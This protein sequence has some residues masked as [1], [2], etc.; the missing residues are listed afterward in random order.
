MVVGNTKGYSTVV[1]AMVAAAVVVGTVVAY[2]L[3]GT[4]N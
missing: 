4:E 2:L 3:F 1:E